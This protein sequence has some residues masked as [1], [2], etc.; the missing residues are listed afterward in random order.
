VLQSE[1]AVKLGL[2]R[3]FAE[4]GVA[5]IDCGRSGMIASQIG[6]HFLLEHQ[7][8]IRAADSFLRSVRLDA[9]NSMIIR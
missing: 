1:S 2:L 7:F 9:E 8:A 6:M 3:L 5:F 4:H